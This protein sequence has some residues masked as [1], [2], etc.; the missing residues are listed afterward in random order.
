MWFRLVTVV[1]RYFLYLMVALTLCVSSMGDY[2][3]SY[4]DRV[5]APLKYS[6]I[7]WELGHLSD[8]WIYRLKNSVFK[9]HT[10]DRNSDLLEVREYFRLVEALKE[11]TKLI[12][13]NHIETARLSGLE[14]KIGSN[15]EVD[16]L[17]LSNLSILRG[18]VEATIETELSEVLK[19]LQLNSRLGL[20][21]PVDIVL[22][23]APH[24]LV[25]SPRDEINIKNTFLLSYGLTPAQKSY[26]EEQVGLL[27]NHSVLVEDL[28]GVAVYPSVISNKLSMKSCLTVAAHEWLHHWLFFKP[29]G[30]SFWTSHE[31]TVLNETVATVAGEEIGALLYD[32]INHD[33]AVSYTHLRAHE[34]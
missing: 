33:V 1:F 30:Q 6:F 22:S 14:R 28:G 25:I 17:M 11:R 15:S 27:D 20:W 3:P 24:I 13:D 10:K 9:N 26:I 12:A 31:M 34:T 4:V 8:K 2:R 23:G 19:S 16:E 29:L 21:P 5:V 18:R 7:K 32:R